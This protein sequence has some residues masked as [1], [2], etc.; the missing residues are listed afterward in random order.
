MVSREQ[1]DSFRK[2]GF[3]N[4]GHVLSTEETNQR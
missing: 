4:Y 1:I 3:L 2:D